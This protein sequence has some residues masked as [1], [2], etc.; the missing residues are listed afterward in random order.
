MAIDNKIIEKVQKKLFELDSK[1]G[2]SK[3]EKEMRDLLKEMIHEK[4][5]D[6]ISG[7][8]SQ[9]LIYQSPV[10]IMILQKNEFVF[11]NPTALK[12]M[13]HETQKEIV[14]KDIFDVINEDYHNAINKALYAAK[15]G[16]RNEPINLLFCPDENTNIYFKAL[17]YP[18]IYNGKPSILVI[19]SDVTAENMLKQSEA[20]VMG[21]FK[22]ANVGIALS[23][24][25][26]LSHVNNA[27]CQMTGY[28]EDELINRSTM[29]IYPS[30]DEYEWVEVELYRQIN[31][32]GFGSIESKF[33]TRSGEFLDVLINASPLNIKDISAGLVFMVMDISELN[34]ARHEIKESEKQLSNLIGN[35]P[36][37][38]YKCRFDEDYTLV[39]VNDAVEE[40]TGYKK[41][42][43]LNNKKVN[44][45]KLIHP[46]DLDETERIVHEAIS[47]DERYTLE[48]RIVNKDNE[49]KWVWEKGMAV[50]DEKGNIAYLEGFIND[51]TDR[52]IFEKEINVSYLKIKKINKELQKA[53][54]KAEESDRLKTRFLNNISHEIRTPLNGIIGFT[55]FLMEPGISHEKKKEYHNIIMSSS[56]QLLSIFMDIIDISRLEAG[57]VKPNI[58][59]FDINELV[60]FVY[61]AHKSVVGRDVEFLARKSEPVKRIEI[62]NDYDKISK[63][64]GH[65]ITN[66]SKFTES[67]QISFGYEIKGDKLNL[68]IKDTGIGIK[69]EYQSVIFERF[70]QLGDRQMEKSKG[71]GLGLS[72]CKEYCELLGGRISVDSEEGKGTSFQVVLPLNLKENDSVRSKNREGSGRNPKILIAE[73]EM[74]NQLYFSELFESEPYDIL[75][76]KNGKE[77]LE[78]M[79]KEKNIDLILMD[80]KMPVMNGYQATLEIRK[81]HPDLPIIAQTAYAMKNDERRALQIGCNEYISKP[82]NVPTLL[83]MIEKYLSAD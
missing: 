43:V 18:L 9:H 65:L 83:K 46:D 8:L 27:L 39:F 80:I 73:D 69:P 42:D 55:D 67:G 7:S 44:F 1:S 82:V 60:D 16:E 11:V 14:G 52:K 26:E 22:S 34:Q 51:I 6:L 47:K 57:V 70:R 4:G 5:E 3:D 79:K 68:F 53:K 21:L 38:V 75:F 77:V 23:V 71:T 29:L 78:I 13:G 58:T 40:I 2:L 61:D 31:K 62:S 66:A 63:I 64:L 20:T 74:S 25:N 33:K 35:L 30:I 15:K 12:W 37:I 48:Y 45:F 50:K 24:N 76:A 32:R 10:S 41:S 49:I 56:D 54:E 72:I 19:G 81:T 59:S 36:G 28:S 17:L